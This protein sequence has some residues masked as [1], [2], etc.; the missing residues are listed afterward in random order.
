[1]NTAARSS[2]RAE[3]SVQSGSALQPEQRQ[4]RGLERFPHPRGKGQIEREE[5]GGTDRPGRQHGLPGPK[6]PFSSLSS[7]VRKEGRVGES[8]RKFKRDNGPIPEYHRSGIP[9]CIGHIRRRWS[10]PLADHFLRRTIDRHY[11]PCPFSVI[12][13]NSSSSCRLTIPSG[14]LF[15]AVCLRRSS[16]TFVELAGLGAAPPTPG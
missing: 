16:K 9:V 10:I 12:S 2:R 11:F 3:L 6:L 14:S 4:W 7:P 15:Y 1:M 5:D 8:A 13:G